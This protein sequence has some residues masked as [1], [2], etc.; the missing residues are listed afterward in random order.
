MLVG[1]A[2][3]LGGRATPFLEDGL[4]ATLEKQMWQVALESHSVLSA[5]N[6]PEH[7]TQNAEYSDE[8][9]ALCSIHNS[10]KFSRAKEYMYICEFT[11]YLYQ[12]LGQQFTV[13]HSQAEADL[14]PEL[15]G[16]FAIKMGQTSQAEINQHIKYFVYKHRKLIAESLKTISEDDGFLTERDPDAKIVLLNDKIHLLWSKSLGADDSLGLE[17]N[18]HPIAKLECD[19]D[20]DNNGHSLKCDF[21]QYRDAIINDAAFK[22]LIKRFAIEQKASETDSYAMKAIHSRI[23]EVLHDYDQMSWTSI[24]KPFKMIFNIN[25]D[26]FTFVQDQG[27]HEP[28]ADV[29]LKMI[30]LTGTLSDLQATTSEQY[31]R[32]TW[33]TIECHLLHTLQRALR[34]YDRSFPFQNPATYMYPDRTKIKVSI[35]ESSMRVET[36]GT[37]HSI[38]EVGEQIGWLAT[39]LNCANEDSQFPF[40][41]PEILSFQSEDDYSLRAGEDEFAKAFVCRL[42]IANDETIPNLPSINGQ[43]WHALFNNPVVVKGYPINPRR[44]PTLE[45]G[46]ELPF[47]MMTTLADTQYLTTFEDK[48]VIKGFSTALIPTGMRDNIIFWHLLVNK[49]GARIPYGDTRMQQGILLG[50]DQLRGGYR[51]VVGWCAN[52]QNNIGS[53]NAN[54]DIKWSGLSQGRGGFAWDRLEFS[55]G[56]GEYLKVSTTFKRGKKER[57]ICVSPNGLRSRIDY[58]GQH[59]FTLYDATERRAYLSDGL[60]VLLHLIR[61]SLKRGEKDNSQDFYQ[62]AIEKLSESSLSAQGSQTAKDVLYNSANWGIKL[63]LDDIFVIEPK[64]EGDFSRKSGIEPIEVTHEKYYRLGDRIKEICFVLERAIE[65]TT[66]AI[67][68]GALEGK[69]RSFL[70]GFNFMDVAL[71]KALRPIAAK[72][73]IA[74]NDV[75]W[76]DLV[77]SLEALTLFGDDFGEL[78]KP[79]AESAS[80]TC[81]QCGFEASLPSGKDYLAVCV[82]VLE[83]ILEANNGNKD[84]TP[85][86]LIDDLHWNIDENAFKA[87]QCTSYEIELKYLAWSSSSHLTFEWVDSVIL[88]AVAPVPTPKL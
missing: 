80:K 39:A 87:C 11:K 61:A 44:G 73:Q 26:L 38:A 17:L 14:L 12:H 1:G 53:P 35:G 71:C 5:T 54:Y 15:L 42:E 32:Q 55:V 70:S 49:S 85:W 8:S 74:D 59:Y 57:S 18:R 77:S 3:T 6:T 56:A 40:R 47:D 69:P 4:A 27:Y 86:R 84:T 68:E 36:I 88:H 83:R 41:H 46:L 9:H 23:L 62:Q 60:P 50:L 13:K 22:W 79:T 52:A 72:L 64:I 78:I 48:T 24:S 21:A 30:T 75:G 43:C 66:K 76:T 58:I 63:Y 51:H 25:C 67:N 29:I 31:F 20:G 7:A 34:A 16:A 10:T 45:A 37:A 33:P 81:S 82:S 19:N 28:A 2:Y 65:Q